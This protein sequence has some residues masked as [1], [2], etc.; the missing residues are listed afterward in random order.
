MHARTDDPSRRPCNEAFLRGVHV[1]EDNDIRVGYSTPFDALCDPDLQADAF[2]WAA[3]AK[4]EAGPQP[5]SEGGPS[6]ES[7]NPARLG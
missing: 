7:L 2:T 4:Q 1:D 6:V 5:S 3:S